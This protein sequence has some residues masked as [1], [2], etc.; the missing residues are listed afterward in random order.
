[1]PLQ[2]G[3][4]GAKTPVPQFEGGTLAVSAALR[5]LE[6]SWLIP[7]PAGLADPIVESRNASGGP[8]QDI[9]NQ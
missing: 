1:M 6:S 2:R 8:Y 4:N 9:Y 5:T 3:A 7:G